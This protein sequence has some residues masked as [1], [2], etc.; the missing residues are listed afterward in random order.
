MSLL[1]NILQGFGIPFSALMSVIF[2]LMIVSFP[3]GAYAIFNSDIGT[4]IDYSFPLE[5]FDMFIAAL[6]T[7]VG[8][9]SLAASNDIFISKKVTYRHYSATWN[10]GLHVFSSFKGQSP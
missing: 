2:G 7:P 5:K 10:E 6:K 8:A 1:E 9:S 3:L 4:D